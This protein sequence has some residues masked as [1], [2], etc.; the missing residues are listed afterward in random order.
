MRQ[1]KDECVSDAY[2]H[3]RRAHVGVHVWARGCV[4]VCFL[5]AHASAAEPCEHFPSAWTALWLGS[6]AFQ[7]A[8]AFNAN[9]GAW[10]TAFVSDM[11]SACAAFRPAARTAANSVYIHIYL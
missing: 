8:H 4:C 1:Y 3:H 5:G 9:I 10:N 7:L 6:Q 2:E 11:Q